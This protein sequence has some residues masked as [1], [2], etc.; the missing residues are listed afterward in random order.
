MDKYIIVKGDVSGI[1]DFIF[2]VKS[3][4]AAYELKGRSFFVKLL[5]EVAMKYILD[6]FKIADEETGNTKISTS[7][8]NFILKLPQLGNAGELINKAQHLFTKNLQF[9]GLNICLAWSEL[10]PDNFGNTLRDIN[11]KLRERKLSLF[12]GD[13]SFFEPYSREKFV[14]NAE[15]KRDKENT[16]KNITTLIRNN[17]GIVIEKSEETETLTFANSNLHLAGYKITFSSSGD[18]LLKNY[19]ESLFPVNGNRVKSFEELSKTD[20]S[21][22]YNRKLEWGGKRGVNKIGVL[23]M[24]VDG[25]GEAIKKCSGE[26][27]LRSFDQRLQYFFNE[28]LLDRIINNKDLYYNGGKQ[29]I[30]RFKN[31]VYTVTAGGDDSFFVGKWN[32]LLDLAIKIRNEFISYFKDDNLTISAGLVIIDPKFPVV[33]F[34]SLAEKALKKAKY[35]Y[36]T[37]GNIC[38]FKEVLDWDIL[39]KDVEELRKL[40]IKNRVSGGILAKARLTAVR[41]MDNKVGLE[42][43][44]KMGYYLRDLKK[45]KDKI[46]KIIHGNIIK[47]VNSPGE[48]KKRNYRLI[49]P[50]AA[51]LAELDNRN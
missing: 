50:V 18:I 46:Q 19:L 13:H 28:F 22:K 3:D 24:D 9:T 32:T 48:L 37:K 29:K 11:I 27:Q 36:K 44:W 35:K 42:D 47:S 23:A 34:A 39:S 30:P 4:G 2:N 12:N 40:F 8:G 26:D 43:F 7:G 41:G 14:K 21:D 51:R 10:D 15:K 31:K 38:L 33:R 49:T 6:E 17:K 5:G 1:Q 16:W 45:D 20:F 25:L